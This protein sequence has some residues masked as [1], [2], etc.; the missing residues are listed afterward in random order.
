MN[1][2]TAL[3]KIINDIKEGKKPEVS[4]EMQ[5]LAEEV[6]RSQEENSEIDLEKWA[7]HLAKDVTK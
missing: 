1:D 6:I 3:R 7:E 2:F 5:K 4:P